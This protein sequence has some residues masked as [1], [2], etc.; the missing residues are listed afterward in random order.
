MILSEEEIFEIL[1]QKERW[2]VL[3]TIGP[4]GFPHSVPIGYFLVGDT[5]VMG[6]K[7]GT[8]KVKNVERE[9]RVSL[10]WENGRGKEFLIG[11][12]FQGHARVVRDDEERLFLKREACR[13]RGEELPESVGK[14]FVYIELSPEKIIS[15]KR[16]T[17]RKRKSSEEERK[18]I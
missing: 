14:G 13:Q 18:P 17:S 6:C 7:D 1:S 5:I 11:I 12:L 3:T 10:L 16:P 4:R 2:V 8:Q 9:S 15:W